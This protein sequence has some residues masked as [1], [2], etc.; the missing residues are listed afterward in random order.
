MNTSSTPNQNNI[1]NPV[2]MPPVRVYYYFCSHFYHI[3]FLLSLC[4][5]ILYSIFFLISINLLNKNMYIIFFIHL[6]ICV[7][8][9]IIQPHFTSSTITHLEH[10]KKTTRSSQYQR[11]NTTRTHQEHHKK[12]TRSPQ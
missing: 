6:L 11:K 7:S 8:F 5:S 12:T 4:S 9:T 3:A 2:L 10:Q 1:Q